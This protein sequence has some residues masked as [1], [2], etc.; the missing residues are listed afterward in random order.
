MNDGTPLK[1]LIVEDVEDDALLLVNA[2]RRSGF[3]VAD[4]RVDKYHH[5][6]P[7]RDQHRDNRLSG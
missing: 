2:L 3:D 4:L 1:T 7:A 5:Q 6:I